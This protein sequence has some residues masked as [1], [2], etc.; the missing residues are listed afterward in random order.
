[1][2]GYLEDESVIRTVSEGLAEKVKDERWC[3]AETQES[4]EGILYKTK[5]LAF[6]PEAAQQEA[7]KQTVDAVIQKAEA[8]GEL[9]DEK[10]SELQQLK[11]AIGT[12][13]KLNVPGS[14]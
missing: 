11:A 9:T 4:P 2:D 1:M 6:F 10:L 8:D 3:P 5:V 12:K 7:A 14:N 13:P